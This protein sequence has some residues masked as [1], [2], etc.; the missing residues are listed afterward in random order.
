MGWAG[1]LSLVCAHETDAAILLGPRASCPPWALAAGQGWPRGS[2]RAGSRGTVRFIQR[3]T[4]A[5]RRRSREP[6]VCAEGSGTLQEQAAE[7]RHLLPKLFLAMHLVRVG[8]G[9]WPS[10]LGEGRVS[11][12]DSLVMSMHGHGPLER[13]VLA[14]RPAV[15]GERGGRRL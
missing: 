9:K 14:E 3:R 12:V 13:V 10:I 5:S 4:Q 2:C 1:C 6:C 8:V 7:H 15:R 11:H